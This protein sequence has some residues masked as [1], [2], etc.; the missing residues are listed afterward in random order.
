[1]PI[2]E[3]KCGKCGHVFEVLQS[4]NKQTEKCEKC[5]AKAPKLPASRVGF[6]FKGSGFYVNDYKKSSGADVQMSR[7]AGK[8][9]DRGQKTDGGKEAQKSGSTGKTEDRS[10]KPEGG[11]SESTKAEK[12]TETKTVKKESKGS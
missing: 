10:Q 6:V 2:Y 7:C 4:K 9:E 8:T 5:G 3:Y 11:K 12:K 1:M